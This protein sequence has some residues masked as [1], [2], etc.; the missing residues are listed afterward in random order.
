MSRAAARAARKSR[1]RIVMLVDNSVHNDSRVQKQARSAAD[2]G[3]DVILIGKS[4]SKKREHFRLGRARV[5]LVPVK[6]RM[7]R[8]GYELRGGLRRGSV[9]YPTKR[10]AKYRRAKAEAHVLDARMSRMR[11]GLAAD[12]S[13]ESLRNRARLGLTKV[14]LG[15]SLAES[16]W[17]N[18]R[19]ESTK[20]VF[21]EPSRLDSPLG[22]RVTETLA[23]VM[24][25]KSWRVLHPHLWDYELA[26]MG[27]IDRLRPDIIHANDFAMIG[28]GANATVRARYSGRSVKLVYDAHEFIAGVSREAHPWWLPAQV[29]YEREYIHEAD[30]VVTVSDVVAEMLQ[31]T[32]GLPERP[33]VVLNAP[34]VGEMS[35]S[36]DAT[37]RM[38]TLCGLDES[39]P[40]LTYSGVMAP[41][42]G[43]QIMVE[44][45]PQLAGVHVAFVTAKPTSRFVVGLMDLATA[46]GVRD[47][48]HLLPYVAPGQVVEYLADADVGVL[49]LHRNLNHDIALATKFYEYSHARL[50][51]VTSDV[52]ATSEMVHH[53]G[54]G[55]VFRAEDLD[56]YVRAVTAVLEQ[57]GKYRAAYDRPGLLEEWTWQKQAEVLD[58]V[59][60]KLIRG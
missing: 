58:V 10:I 57:P 30:A 37:P 3:W 46:L 53:T 24:G 32:H 34:T 36:G 1:G 52:K 25:D 41:R 22:A 13:G 50:P 14:A 18:R 43:V 54:Q 6:R 7:S 49:P 56:D 45:L 17:V 26:Y 35:P 16:A 55:E 12:Q 11:A 28:V 15:A 20:R 4:P 31:Q 9:A 40:L 39:V 48:V 44:A 51:I 60:E 23:R 2:M 29:A 5:R 33:S 21:G 27:L 42:R 38:R 59:Y 8:R 19:A 47:R